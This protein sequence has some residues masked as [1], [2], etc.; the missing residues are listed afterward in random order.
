MLQGPDV[1]SY[2]GYPDWAAVAASGRAFAWTKATEG[3]E[4]GNPYFTGNWQ[5]IRAAGLVRGAYHFAQPDVSSPEAQAEFFLSRVGDLVP[6]DLLALDLEAGSG[7]LLDWALRFLRH[8]AAR[9]FFKPMLYS[10]RWFLDPHGVEA[11]PDLGEYGLWLSGYQADQPALPPG[12]TALAMWQFTDA[13]S[14]PGIVGQVD[15]SYFEGDLAQ[16]AK[17]GKPAPVQEIDTDAQTVNTNVGQA[18]QWMDELEGLVS[19]V[20]C[21]VVADPNPA[22]T[23]YMANLSSEGVRLAE[24]VRVALHAARRA[25]GGE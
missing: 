21:P 18:L 6:G 1:S 15:E 16:L 10:G 25:A 12:W 8:A 14:I 2:Q 20:N 11:N 17:Y 9:V 24:A 13:D 19:D 5:A 22:Y 7:N 4:Y 3:L 23:A